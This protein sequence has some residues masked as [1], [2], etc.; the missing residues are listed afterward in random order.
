MEI[1]RE[2]QLIFQNPE[3]QLM[4]HQPSMAAQLRLAGR[5]GRNATQPCSCLAASMTYHPKLQ[6][7][8]VAND[9]TDVA[10]HFNATKGISD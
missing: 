2:A 6:H 7:C 1:L 5:R 8:T 4:S 3:A 10:T 9:S